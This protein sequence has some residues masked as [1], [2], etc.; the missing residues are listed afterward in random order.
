MKGDYV[1]EATLVTS[2]IIESVSF[3]H[4]QREKRPG[5]MKNDLPLAEVLLAIKPSHFK[6]AYLISHKVISATQFYEPSFDLRLF[7][8][9]F[10]VQTTL[11]LLCNAIVKHLKYEEL[12]MV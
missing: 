9:W 2:M 12:L 6:D 10:F 8:F 4:H 5:R 3:H 11:K 1:M 7:L